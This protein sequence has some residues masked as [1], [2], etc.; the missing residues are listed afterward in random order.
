MRTNYHALLEEGQFY[1]IY[2]RT[3]GNDLLFLQTGNYIF[4]LNKWKKYISNYCETYS[5]CLMSN[6]FHFIIRV[7]KV[8]EDFRKNVA[9]EGTTAA[10]KFLEDKISVNTFL[11]DQFKRFFNAY[12]AAFNKQH[13]RH[14]SLF[15]KRF[16]RV[17]INSLENLKSKICYVHHNPI[18]HGMNYF[19]DVWP[20]SSYLAYTTTKPTLVERQ[21]GLLL[22]DTKGEVST[23]IEVHE[24]YQKSRLGYK[25]D[26]IEND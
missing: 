5:Y 8:N 4:F 25:G 2:N 26:D 6:H 17:L 12:A 14:G 9:L 19:Y 10:Q 11:E 16:K 1:H 15:Q 24:L 21:K 18:H 13:D 3:N 22:F 7:K 23:F 20:Y